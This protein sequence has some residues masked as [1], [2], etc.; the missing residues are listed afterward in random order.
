M[1]KRRTNAEAVAER[2]IDQRKPKMRVVRGAT[3]HELDIGHRELWPRLDE[4]MQPAR[5]HRGGPGAEEVRTDHA[6]RHAVESHLAMKHA[7]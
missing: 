1:Q 4:G 6:H 5:H 7:G 3:E 2:R